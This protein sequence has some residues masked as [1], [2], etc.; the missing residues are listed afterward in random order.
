LIGERALKTRRESTD[1]STSPFSP[2]SFLSLF[3]HLEIHSKTVLLAS[4]G[5]DIVKKSMARKGRYLLNIAAALRPTAAG[6][7]VRR[8]FLMASERRTSNALSSISFQRSPTL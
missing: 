5:K 2:N 4:G 6:K 3:L 8:S 7:M 1:S